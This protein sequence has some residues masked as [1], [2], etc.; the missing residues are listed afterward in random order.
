MKNKVQSADINR[1]IWQA[2][3]TFRGVIDPGQYKDYI[4]VMLFLKYVSDTHTEK[5]EQYLAQYDGDEARAK[6]AMSSER[7]IIPEHR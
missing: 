7:F 4:L 2:C 1:I 6:R 3:D 5:Y